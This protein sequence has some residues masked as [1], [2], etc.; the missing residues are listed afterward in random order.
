M[1][2]DDLHGAAGRA[3]RRW[4]AILGARPD[5][6][7]AVALQR[8]LVARI[9]QADEAL[10]A[11]AVRLPL[12]PPAAIEARLAGG[13]PALRGCRAPLPVHVLVPL[14]IDC[15]RLLAGEGG[16]EAAGRVVEALEGGRINAA[17]LLAASLARDERSIRRTAAHMGFAPD[18]LW[19][20]G[21]LGVGVAAH[22]FQRL[23][24]ET[25]RLARRLRP[26]L[27]AWSR[28]YCPAC[29]S[30]PAFGEMRAGCRALRCSFCEAGWQP[31]DRRCVYCG[32]AN[33]AFAVTPAPPGAAGWLELCAGC[34]GYLK[35]VSPGE[36]LP[37]PAAAIE[38]LASVALDH[39]AVHDGYG[40]PPLAAIPDVPAPSA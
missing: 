35:V 36:P 31:L 19:L 30:W 28:G 5:L 9:A 20:L 13:V 39:A 21:D 38:D 29:G 27:E 2:T 4:Q 37:F 10:A 22:R 32:G 14:T 33:G 17:S 34:R 25:G 24:F 8:R 40:R 16:S 23:L 1:M 15:A 6:Q 18:L 7:P 26:A 11:D 12:E 3:E